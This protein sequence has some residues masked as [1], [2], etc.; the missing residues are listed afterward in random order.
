MKN[1]R[2]ATAF[3]AVLGT[4]AMCAAPVAAQGFDPVRGAGNVTITFNDRS[5]P[6]WD[7][8]NNGVITSERFEAR[9]GSL[10]ECASHMHRSFNLLVN[11][12]PVYEGFYEGVFGR[13]IEG[14]VGASLRARCVDT[15]TGQGGLVNRDYNTLR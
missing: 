10:Q 6:V 11:R 5:S 4:S 8:T 12:M 1:L 15:R 3:S 14:K 2:L 13:N 7:L 9:F